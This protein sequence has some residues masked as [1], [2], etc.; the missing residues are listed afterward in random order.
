MLSLL[1]FKLYSCIHKSFINHSI[2]I[3]T[4]IY[5][6]CLTF[7]CEKVCVFF[8]RTSFLDSP[9]LL[10]VVQKCQA[11]KSD[12]ILRF[13]ARMI[14][15]EFGKILIF[16]NF[17]YFNNIHTICIIMTLLHQNLFYLIFRRVASI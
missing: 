3:K 10:L 14:C 15:S 13:L 16:V 1:C 5:T 9:G 17:Q 2:Y 8:L 4:Y 6:Y 12:C 11:I 7:T